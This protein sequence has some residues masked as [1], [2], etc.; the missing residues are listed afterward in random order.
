M[1]YEE[2]MKSNNLNS[3]FTS[4][5]GID[6]VEIK[7]GCAKGE[8]LVTRHHENEIQSIHGGCL[9]ASADAIGGVAASAKGNRATTVSGNFH[10]L[11]PGI[12]VKK[13][14]AVATEQLLR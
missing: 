6:V 5:L 4:Y 13:L 2:T 1:T 7:P 12:G 11:S 10:F 3:G 8:M 9:F 14:T